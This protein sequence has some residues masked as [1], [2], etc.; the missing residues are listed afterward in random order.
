MSHCKSC[1]IVWASVTCMSYE[2]HVSLKVA[3]HDQCYHHESIL[4]QAPDIICTAHQHLS[5]VII[6]VLIQNKKMRV[7]NMAMLFLPNCCWG[8][9]ATLVRFLVII[10]I[11]DSYACTYLDVSTPLKFSATLFLVT[12]W[13]SLHTFYY[14]NLSIYHTIA[15]LLFEVV[16]C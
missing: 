6:S 15:V 16:F 13:A 3:T 11:I 12:F 4:Y 9:V 8:V 7:A 2:Q 1:D 5:A 14:I 10:V